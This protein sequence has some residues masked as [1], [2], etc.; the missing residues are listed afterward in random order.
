MTDADLELFAVWQEIVVPTYTVTFNANGG[1]GEMEPQVV[2][3]DVATA[4]N[5]NE[6]TRENYQ[7][8][9][10]STTAEGEVEYADKAEVTLTDADLELFAVWQEIV[11]SSY[12]VT[13]KANGGDGEMEP[14]TVEADVATALNANEFT[15]SGY[16]FIGW[17]TTAEGEVEYADKAEVTLTD[18][19]L[20]LFAV[21]QRSNIAVF[22]N[23]NGGEGLMSPHRLYVGETINLDAV[24]YTFKGKT[25]AG[26]STTA[27]GEV[28][29][30]DG[31]EFTMG[32]KSTILYAVW[33]DGSTPEEPP[34]EPPENPDPRAV[35]FNPNGGTG[36]MT[37]IKKLAT[38]DVITLPACSYANGSLTFAGWA[39]TADG[40]VVYG[41][42]DSYT[43]GSVNQ[44]LYAIWSE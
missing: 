36:L 30:A 1:D 38:G 19:D 37:P 41:D 17:S 6:F 14:Q 26:W 40:E 23:P 44:V 8:I 42:C 9:G 21:W 11:V 7:F 16:K 10:W 39:L 31:A 29:Y 15:R 35:L 27:D 20:E 12:K 5:A 18:S 22:F 13:F 32:E 24:G 33:T 2:D 28:E 25:F 34:V 4:L 43:V 3:A